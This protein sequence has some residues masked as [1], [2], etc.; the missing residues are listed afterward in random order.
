MRGEKM[1]FTC[2]ID[3]TH[4]NIYCSLILQHKSTRAHVDA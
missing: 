3:C 4:L 1:D 2:Y